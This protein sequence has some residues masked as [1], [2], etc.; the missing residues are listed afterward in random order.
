MDVTL[1]EACQ[2]EK[3]LIFPCTDTLLTLTNT[4]NFIFIQGHL[5]KHWNIGYCN[6]FAH[7]AKCCK[8]RNHQCAVLIYLLNKR[9]IDGAVVLGM[10][11]EKPWLNPSLSLQQLR[12]KFLTQLRA[13]ISSAQ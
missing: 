12:M 8:W 4:P 1:L 13:S 2:L 11:K 7:T 10:S 6:R 3:L 9:M 5:A